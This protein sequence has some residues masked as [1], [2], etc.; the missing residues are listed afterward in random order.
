MTRQVPKYMVTRLM[1]GQKMAAELTTL[2]R[3]MS[4]NEG[5]ME[6]LK[7]MQ[8]AENIRHVFPHEL[9]MNE[10]RLLYQEEGQSLYEDAHH[11]T[12]KGADKIIRSIIQALQP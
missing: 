12:R 9:M 6:F 7:N 3:Y 11:V 10:G 2:Q 5:I 8:P 4:T 1:T